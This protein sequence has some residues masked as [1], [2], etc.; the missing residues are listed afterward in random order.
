[1]EKAYCEKLHAQQAE[2][3]MKAPNQQQ[4]ACAGQEYTD[5]AAGVLAGL[6]GGRQGGALSSD[7]GGAV[8]YPPPPAR[9][10][11][12]EASEIQAIANR[13]EDQVRILRERL[14]GPFPCGNPALDNRTSP[15]SLAELLTNSRDK[16]VRVCDE[17][18]L[19]LAKSE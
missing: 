7:Y 19:L 16:L 10:L 1:M 12:Q 2:A 4:Q 15:F 8:T 17:V 3:Q 14:F 13:L 5:R 6:L 11:C 9:G 18:D